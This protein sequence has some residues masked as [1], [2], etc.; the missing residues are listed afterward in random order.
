MN[1]NR[2]KNSLILSQKLRSIYF[3]RDMFSID[4]ILKQRKMYQLSAHFQIELS[5]QIEDSVILI[6]LVMKKVLVYF[7]FNTAE[8]NPTLTRTCKSS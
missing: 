6:L 1:G 7:H 4:D 8:K 3:C 5:F 2:C